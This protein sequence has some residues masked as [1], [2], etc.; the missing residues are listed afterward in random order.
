LDK[1]A[2]EEGVLR[3]DCFDSN[4]IRNT[5]IGAYSIDASMIYTMNKEHEIYRRSEGFFLYV[6]TI[7]IDLLRWVPLIDDHDAEDIG[8]QG[9]L[10]ISIQV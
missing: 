7:Y 5:L 2:F 9:Y 3:I 4:I 10:K 1:S 8:V 6:Y